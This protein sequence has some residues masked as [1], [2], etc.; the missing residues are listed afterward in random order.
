MA[1]DFVKGKQQF[2]YTP[3]FQK[4]FIL[5]RAIDAFT[6]AHPATKALKAFFAPQYRLYAG[7][8]ADVVYDHFLACDTNIFPTPEALEQ[9][10]ATTYNTLDQFQAAFPIGFARMLPYMRQQDWLYHYRFTTGIEQS[11][12]GL[13]RRA[14]YL[15]ESAIAYRVF[16]ENYAA[17]GNCYAAF[18]P[19]LK[20]HSIYQLQQL[21]AD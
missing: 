18:F 5:H 3:G 21:L 14:A 12:N 10:A 19:E 4:G 13:V 8:F 2:T 17:M 15:S 6:D 1:N 9:F 11:F 16:L 7:A 20:K